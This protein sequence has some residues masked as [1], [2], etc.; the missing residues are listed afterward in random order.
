MIAITI[1][2]TQ[3]SLCAFSEHGLVLEGKAP[4]LA[5][6]YPSAGGSSNYLLWEALQNLLQKRAPEKSIPSYRD[7]SAFARRYAMLS[8]AKRRVAPHLNSPAMKADAKQ[9]GFCVYLSA[10]LLTGL[11]LNA[12]SVG[13]RG[14]GR[15]CPEDHLE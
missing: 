15:F 1:H 11:L 2:P 6:C 14:Q 5:A 4:Q 7:S 9:V 8:G 12:R 10:I 3:R 13:P